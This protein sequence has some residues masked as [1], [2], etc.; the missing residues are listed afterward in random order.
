[1]SRDELTLGRDEGNTIRLTERNVSRRH[2]R[3]IRQGEG[4]VA[5]DRSRYGS[6]LNGRRFTGRV[7]LSNGDVLVVGDYR[8]SIESAVELPTT[9]PRPPQA[10]FVDVG[11]PRL[12]GRSDDLLGATWQLQGRCVIGAGPHAHLRLPGPGVLQKHA[13]LAPSPEGWRIRVVDPASTI[14]VNGRVERDRLLQRG[15]LITIGRAEL[16]YIDRPEFFV[17]QSPQ[18][19]GDRVRPPAH[20]AARL[21]TTGTILLLLLGA[22]ALAMFL[23]GRWDRPAPEQP[24]RQGATQTI[25]TTAFS[26]ASADHQRYPAGWLPAPPGAG[27]SR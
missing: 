22:G 26:R 9:P 27:T 15:D 3:I 10:G 23:L 12:M 14:R 24:G 20:P 18:A 19:V 25:A 11:V 1:M 8:I 6:M 17:S 2:M 5:E 13:E 7:N 21:A 16:L 4:L